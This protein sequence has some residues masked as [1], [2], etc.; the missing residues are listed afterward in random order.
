MFQSKVQMKQ[1]QSFRLMKKSNQCFLKSCLVYYLKYFLYFLSLKLARFSHFCFFTGSDF[2]SFFEFK[3]LFFF[4]Y[5][6]VFFIF[7]DFSFFAAKAFFLDWFYIFLVLYY[8][9]NISLF[10]MMLCFKM[11]ASKVEKR[12]IFQSWQ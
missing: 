7:L 8:A 2:H 12:K 9:N 3:I 10:K 4:L 11:N 6:V 5:F 1:I